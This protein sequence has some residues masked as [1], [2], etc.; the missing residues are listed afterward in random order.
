MQTFIRA[1]TYTFIMTTII[2]S[3]VIFVFFNKTLNISILYGFFTAIP[4][5]LIPSYV[6]YRKHLRYHILDIQTSN[7]INQLKKLYLLT[8]YKQTL[9]LLYDYITSSKEFKIIK[10]YKDKGIIEISIQDTLLNFDIQPLT[11]HTSALQISL[12]GDETHLKNILTYIKSKET[13]LLNY[14]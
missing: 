13:D 8:D 4:L 7:H 3:I 1:Y 9:T 11:K 5:N 14:R 10:N 2:C 12:D 6:W